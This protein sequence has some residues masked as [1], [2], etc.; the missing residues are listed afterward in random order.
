MGCLES[1]EEQHRDVELLAA[2]QS[3]DV[4][5]ARA[6]LDSGADKE[7]K[8]GRVRVARQQGA[9]RRAHSR[10]TRRTLRA[11]HNDPAVLGCA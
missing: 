8:G 3:G 4:E 11:E 1:K 2:A 10:V 9:L 6:A 5:A 7:C